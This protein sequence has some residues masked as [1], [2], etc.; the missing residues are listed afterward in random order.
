MPEL[1]EVEVVRSTLEGQIKNH[2]IEELDCFYLPIIEDDYPVFRNA[3]LKKKILKIGRYAKYLIFYLENGTILSHLRMEGKFYFQK[4]ADPLPKYVHVIFHLD[5]GFRLAYG[6]MRKFGRL[7]F[8]T[9]EDLFKIAPLVHMGVEA[10]SNQI[11]ID[12]L[13][14]RIHKKSLPVKSILLDQ[15]IIA[16][17]GNI[18][19]DE[20][21]FDARIDPLKKG[22]ELTEIEIKRIVESSKKI[23]DLAILHKGT[24]IRSY[25]SS[26][27][28]TG[29]YQDYLNVH[30]KT[31]C[32][33]CNR[34][35]V[36]IKIGGR[37]SYY[38]K[39]CQR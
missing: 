28:V 7:A 33:V 30:T 19:A 27:G 10:N 34:A 21:L 29:S 1:P 38:C 35:L 13:F 15:H 32:P 39:K 26:L 37:T 9:K 24:T 14:Q 25:T 23:L 36:K 22:N 20:V 16:G 5:G 17:L 18:Y 12:C 4:E 8:R 11:D 3:V 2:I 31:V 6:D